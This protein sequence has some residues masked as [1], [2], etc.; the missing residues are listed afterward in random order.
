MNGEAAPRLVEMTLWNEGQLLEDRD[1]MV[2]VVVEEQED[3][4]LRVLDGHR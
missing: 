3:E 1:G 2:L 4:Q